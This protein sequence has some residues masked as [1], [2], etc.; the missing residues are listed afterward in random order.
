MFA[1][2]FALSHVCWLVAYPLAG[3]VG[4]RAGMDAAL[5]ASAAL[6]LVGTLLAIRIWPQGDPDVLAHRHDDLQPDHPHLRDGHAGGEARHSFVI[7]E[8]HRQWPDR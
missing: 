5:G 3:Q 6:A 1:A 7:D 2:Q 8:L 4:A